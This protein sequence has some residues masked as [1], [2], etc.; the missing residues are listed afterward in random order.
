M[1][2]SLCCKCVFRSLKVADDVTFKEFLRF[3]L[4]QSRRG[5]MNHHWMP[6]YDTCHPCHVNYDFIG[7]HETLRQDADHVLRH[8]SR[9]VL[10]RNRTTR[11]QFPVR[12]LDSQKRKSGELLRKFYGNISTRII[13]RL[14]RL[15]DRDNEVFGYQLPDII[16][17]R[18][19][20]QPTAISLLETIQ[21]LMDRRSHL[22]AK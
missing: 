1:P 8:I 20:I 19:S 6:Q 12:H 11:V 5:S 17:R 15:Y 22:S 7:H 3:V 18:L 14:L 2:K 13:F 16:R 4:L 9:L 10:A 21:E